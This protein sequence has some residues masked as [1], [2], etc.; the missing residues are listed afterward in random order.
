VSLREQETKKRDKNE[1][2]AQN[3]HQNPVVE[4]DH[5]H[6]DC[7]CEKGQNEHDLSLVCLKIEKAE[8]QTW[9]IVEYGQNSDDDENDA[10]QKGNVDQNEKQSKSY[11]QKSRN[12]NVCQGIFENPVVCL[13]H[14][15]LLQKQFF[16]ICST[17]RK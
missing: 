12:Q 13:L 15:N 7:C 3:D 16:I 1:I 14:S 5:R 8:D 11:A 2:D 4:E 17:D 6:A 10:H 9:Q